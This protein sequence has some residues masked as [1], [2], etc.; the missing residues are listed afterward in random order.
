MLVI[1]G[2]RTQGWDASKYMRQDTEDRS[3]GHYEATVALTP[4]ARASA[5]HV[6]Y[7]VYV[8]EQHKPYPD[9]DHER[10]WLTDKLDANA[11]IIIV[12]GTEGPC[13]TVR[14]IF[15]DFEHVKDT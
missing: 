14:A 10:C 5:Y 13:G 9:A 3:N 2:R 15:A 4:E 12:S 8:S 11:A 1:D 7:R 6:R